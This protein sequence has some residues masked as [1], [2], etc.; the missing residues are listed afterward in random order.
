MSEKNR[1]KEMQYV[2]AE[3][4]LKN[5]SKDELDRMEGVKDFFLSR[6]PEINFKLDLKAVIIDYLVDI[7]K[8]DGR[9]ATKQGFFEFFEEWQNYIIKEAQSGEKQRANKGLRTENKFSQ[10]LAEKRG[11]EQLSRSDTYLGNLTADDARKYSEKL[12]KT[13]KNEKPN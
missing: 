4:F 10:A 7:C 1:E 13:P 3:Q 9:L 12:G 5:F 2:F 11:T 6:Y 8:N